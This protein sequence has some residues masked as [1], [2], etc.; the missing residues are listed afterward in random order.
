LIQVGHGILL[1]QNDASQFGSENALQ[2]EA[3]TSDW[4]DVNSKV[5]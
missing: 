3:L 5:I 2:M 1:S 4:N